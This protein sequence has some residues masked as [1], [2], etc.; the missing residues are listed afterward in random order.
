[1]HHGCYDSKSNSNRP[2]K[3]IFVVSSGKVNKDHPY[4]L[5]VIVLFCTFTFHYNL[6]NVAFIIS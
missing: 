4:P 2:G 1:M 3:R 5:K 6:G